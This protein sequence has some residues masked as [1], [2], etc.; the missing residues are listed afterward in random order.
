M[1][2]NETSL[3]NLAL[4]SAGTRA[5]V[6]QPNEQS[7]EAEIC[8]LW[9]EPVRRQIL[10]AASWSS[11]KA[12]SR[13]AL[14]TEQIETWE[15][16]S[17]NPQFRYAYGLPAK[18]LQARFLFDYARFDI[19][20]LFTSESALMTN[21]ERALLYYTFDQTDISMWDPDLY[22]AVAHA[23]AAYI[24]LPLNGKT[25]QARAAQQQ[26]NS[27]IYSAREATANESYEPVDMPPDWIVARGSAYNSPGARY[28]Y[29]TG[30]LISVP[31]V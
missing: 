3:Y 30:P 5:R 13:L 12:I 1:A 14:K 28:V 16:G 29:P 19:S 15:P 7:R 24:C 27:L 22:L 23:L 9:Y 20:L 17:P 21:S 8:R 10:R 26:A 11:A 6:S 18:Y 2:Q 4:S 25:S 31:N